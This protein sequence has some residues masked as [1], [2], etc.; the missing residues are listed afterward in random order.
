[1][2]ASTAAEDPNPVRA[3]LAMAA[4]E[5]VRVEDAQARAMAMAVGVLKVALVATD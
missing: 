3:D 1:V 5:P 4:L 2:R